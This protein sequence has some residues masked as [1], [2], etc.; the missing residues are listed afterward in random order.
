VLYFRPYLLWQRGEFEA[1]RAL[2]EQGFRQPNLADMDFPRQMMVVLDGHVRLALG[3]RDVAKA[4]FSAAEARAREAG[5]GL[6]VTEA[7]LGRGELALAMGKL[8]DAVRALEEARVAA[9]AGPLRNPRHEAIAC[10][11]LGRTMVAERQYERAWAYL[12]RAMAIVTLP[13]QDNWLEQGLIHEAFGEWHQAQGDKTAAGEAYRQ[14]G[15]QY[16]R[17]K[18]RHRLHGVNRRLD[19]LL[20]APMAQA[21]RGVPQAS[22]ATSNQ[23][24]DRWLQLKA[25]QMRGF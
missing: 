9:A 6:V 1:A 12:E 24:E 15:E 4:A 19:S 11:L 14:A 25:M 13:E 17:M 2:L 8:A 3:E 22:E 18:N 7:L 21:T 20:G 23:T 5:M 16:H 10:R